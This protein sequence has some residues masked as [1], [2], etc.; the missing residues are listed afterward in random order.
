V[1]QGLDNVAEVVMAG[2]C[3]ELER[4]VRSLCIIDAQVAAVAADPAADPAAAGA[5]PTAL[6]CSLNRLWRQC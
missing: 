5:L 2:Q 1:L 6:E 4:V 3:E